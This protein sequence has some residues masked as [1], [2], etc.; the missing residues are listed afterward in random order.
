MSIPGI[1][2][3]GGNINPDL[4]SSASNKG[5]DNSLGGFQFGNY[6]KSKGVSP[7]L[8]AGVVVVVLW[9][10]FKGSKR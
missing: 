1:D 8:I 9:L 10:V 5:G 4:G 2:S 7:L 6:S 3:G